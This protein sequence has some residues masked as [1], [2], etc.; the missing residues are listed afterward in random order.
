MQ[1]REGRSCALLRDEPSI[2]GGSR[3]GILQGAAIAGPLPTPPCGLPEAAR[4]RHARRALADAIEHG[5]ALLEALGLPR[6]V[7]HDFE[8]IDPAE[9]GNAIDAVISA[10]DDLDAPGEDLED[11]EREDVGDDEHTLGAP[12]RHPFVFTMTAGHFRTADGR[13]PRRYRRDES[14][15]VWAQGARQDGEGEA[16]PG[17]DL[18]EGDDERCA[19]DDVDGEPS[20]GSLDHLDQTAWA[21]GG[22]GSGSDRELDQLDNF[23]P[24]TPEQRAACAQGRQIGTELRARAEAIRRRGRPTTIKPSG[25]LVLVDASVFNALL[26]HLSWSRL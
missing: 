8:P 3:R 1:K 26:P 4:A 2:L 13:E 15:A 14:Q 5:V 12:E 25:N 11:D 22:E 7:T 17:Y 16:E 23:A 9:I 19:S 24:W 20:L 10:L 6:L 18:P 21:D